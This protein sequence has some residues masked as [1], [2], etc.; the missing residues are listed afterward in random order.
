MCQ[1]A[2][3]RYVL[4]QIK[5]CTILKFMAL[6]YWLVFFVNS[7]FFPYK[8]YIHTYMPPVCEG[9]TVSLHSFSGDALCIIPALELN[10]F[11]DLFSIFPLSVC[12]SLFEAIP[13]QDF[14]HKCSY[15]HFL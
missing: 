15:Q 4:D 7:S 11:V 3:V 13:T 10:F 8:L 1:F 14:S 9:L 2:A 12:L 6:F 5:A